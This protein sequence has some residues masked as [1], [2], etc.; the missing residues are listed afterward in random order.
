VEEDKVDEQKEENNEMEVETKEENGVQKISKSAKKETKR[1]SKL[2]RK[3]KEKEKKALK[4]AE[5]GIIKENGKV[6]EEKKESKKEEESEKE[7]EEKQKENENQKEKEKTQKKKD[8]KAKK[9]QEKKKEQE[10][11]Q[12]EE[13]KEDEKIEEEQVNQEPV[14]NGTA[15]PHLDFSKQPQKSPG[16]PFRRVREEDVEF[17]DDRLR[18]NSYW[19]KQG[20]EYGRAANKDLVIV[21]GKDFRHAKTKKK[22]G[23]YRGGAI[24]LAVNSIKFANPDE[25]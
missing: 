21:K 4:K 18:N 22:K 25:A 13:T 10:K 15:S 3:R 5:N 11:D 1:I 8:K 9:K 16:V 2:E 7:D 23:T 14:Q 6:K 19:G 24:D 20:D 12:E 17:E